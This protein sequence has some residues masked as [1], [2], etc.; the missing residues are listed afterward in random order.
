M[1]TSQGYHCIIVMKRWLLIN[2]PEEA[3][4]NS[5]FVPCFDQGYDKASFTISLLWLTA[6]YDFLHL[7]L[8]ES[9]LRLFLLYTFRHSIHHCHDMDWP[10]KYAPHQRHQDLLLSRLPC[11]GVGATQQL[12]PLLPNSGR[13]RGDVGRMRGGG[14]T[15]WLP[16]P[17][18]L[19]PFHVFFLGFLWWKTQ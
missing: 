6:L 13:F 17:G 1:V 5:V 3:H 10:P 12:F 15:V 9:Y 2:Y 16:L 18:I 8:Y 19:H 14:C 4:Y 7:I 11:C